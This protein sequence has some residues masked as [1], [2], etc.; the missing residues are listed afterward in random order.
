[1]K[2]FEGQYKAEVLSLSAIRSDVGN[3][4]TKECDLDTARTGDFQILV[5]EVLQNIIRYEYL[6]NGVEGHI[7]I[8]IICNGQGIQIRVVDDAPPLKDISFLSR[9][10]VAS[11]HGG[12]GLELIRNLSKAY[13]INPFSYGNEHLITI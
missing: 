9:S 11:E 3:F 5:G 6:I 13:T 1:M 8:E 2:R 7:H 12:M 4:L 10:P